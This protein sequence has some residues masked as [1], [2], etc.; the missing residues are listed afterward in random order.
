MI[1][2]AVHT[3]GVNLDGLLA[4]AVAITIIVGFLGGLLLRQINRSIEDKIV[5]AVKKAVAPLEEMVK[6]HQ[7]ILDK[8]GQDISYL[9]GMQ[10]GKRMALDELV[11]SAKT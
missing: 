3:T 5:D 4:N 8:H 1:A 2:A 6:V 11:Q 7:G 9:K 10:E